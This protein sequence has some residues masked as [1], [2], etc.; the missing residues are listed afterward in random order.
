MSFSLE[1]YEQPEIKESTVYGC[2]VYY[3]VIVLGGRTPAKA[4]IIFSHHYFVA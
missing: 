3:K 4:L 1:S 2:V